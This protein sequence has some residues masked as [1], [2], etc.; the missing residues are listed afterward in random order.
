IASLL[1]FY[2]GATGGT[3]GEAGEEIPA[4]PE[5]APGPGAAARLAGGA[6]LVALLLLSPGAPA[7][8]LAAAQPAARSPRAAPAAAPPAVQPA[9]RPGAQ[10]ATKAGASLSRRVVSYSIQASLDPATRTV[11][12]RESIVYR[13]DT[14]S[15]MSDLKL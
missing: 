3:V 6:A 8:S 12:G 9:A 2:R 1:A 10:P 14:R 7:R 11:S 5:G 13:N 15:T 4:G